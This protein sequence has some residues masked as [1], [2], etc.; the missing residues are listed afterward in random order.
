MW[1]ITGEWYVFD[2]CQLHVKALKYECNNNIWMEKEKSKVLIQFCLIFRQSGMSFSF[3]MPV[4]FA[5]ILVRHSPSF[6]KGHSHVESFPVLLELVS[7]CRE[8]T[9]RKLKRRCAFWKNG[10][11][12]EEIPAHLRSKSPGCYELGPSKPRNSRAGLFYSFGH[13]RTRHTSHLSPFRTSQ[14]HYLDARPVGDWISGSCKP[15]ILARPDTF[16]ADPISQVWR[17]DR[18]NFSG[19][20][21]CNCSAHE[22]D[23][24]DWVRVL[25]RILLRA[26][27]F[28][29]HFWRKCLAGNTCRLPDIPLSVRGSLDSQSNL[30]ELEVSW[31][32]IL[33]PCNHRHRTGPCNFFQEFYYQNRILTFSWTIL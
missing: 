4:G 5:D 26:G 11:C 25:G 12:S 16:H 27:T 22:E 17:D 23:C 8:G 10:Y 33:W 3:F 21:L 20:H 18:C 9:W 1:K 32:L 13:T 14:G 6:V 7:S 24:L 28:H 15:L 19:S 29:L 2:T 31:L 30:Q